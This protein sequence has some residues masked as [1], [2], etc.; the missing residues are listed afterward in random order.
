MEHK[1]GYIISQTKSEIRVVIKTYS[2]LQ[3][4]EYQ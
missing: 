1:F 3:L 2:V 4:S